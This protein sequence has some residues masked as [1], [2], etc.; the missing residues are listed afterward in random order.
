MTETHFFALVITSCPVLCIAASV[1]AKD[2][3][4]PT[5]NQNS[6]TTKPVQENAGTGGKC[7]VMTETDVNQR[8]TAAGTCRVETGGRIS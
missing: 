2:R 3:P 1:F 8:H 4:T 7:P 6:Q 5:D